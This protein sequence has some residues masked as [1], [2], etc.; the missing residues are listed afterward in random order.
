MT[1]A[2]SIIRETS[3][4]IDW[5]ISASVPPPRKR[6]GVVLSP[7]NDPAMLYVGHVVTVMRLH[8]W[9]RMHGYKVMVVNDPHYAMP[10]EHTDLI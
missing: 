2:R 1:I 5:P 6:Y 4:F 9:A 3:M 7:L 8:D 10:H